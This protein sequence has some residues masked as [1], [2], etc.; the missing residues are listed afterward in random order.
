VV[1]RRTIPGVIIVT[2]ASKA[3]ALGLILATCRPTALLRLLNRR[4]WRSDI[5]VDSEHIIS[6]FYG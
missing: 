3:Q 4:N 1:K 5:V 2:R 6:P